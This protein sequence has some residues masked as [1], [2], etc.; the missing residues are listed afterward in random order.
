MLGLS[1]T[2]LSVLI[3]IAALATAL[4]LAVIS[5]YFAWRDRRQSRH[6]DDSHAAFLFRGTVLVDSTPAAQHLL[7]RRATC[8][9][10]S[11]EWEQLLDQLGHTFPG[12]RK[13]ARDGIASGQFLSNRTGD[14][15]VLVVDTWGEMVRITLHEATQRAA[16]VHP[17]AV[18]AMEEELE[19]LRTLSQ[20]APQLM[21]KEDRSGVVTWANRAYLE[22][23]DRAAPPG[24]D[25]GP[26]WP[27]HR[28]FDRLDAATADKPLTRRV[29]VT[30][31]DAPDPLWF[32]VTSQAQGAETAHF[33]TDAGAAVLAE[34][35]GR[36]FVQTLTKTFAQLSIGLAIFDRQRRLVMFNP[37]LLD[38]TRLPVEFLSSRPQIHGFLDRLR[39]RYMLPEPKNYSSWR[40]QVAALEIAAQEGT[41]CESWALPGGQTYKVTGRPHP[42]GAIA[43]T[44]ED[45]TAEI[46]LTRTFRTELETAQNVLEAMEE[47][48]A[49]FSGAG[50]LTMSNAAYS[51]VWGH[52]AESLGEISLKGEIKLWQERTAPTPL[53]ASLSQ[54]AR[55][56]GKPP[57]SRTAIRM[58]DGRA[59]VCRCV[60]IGGGSTLMAFQ[61]L[62]TGSAALPEPDSNEEP[63][64]E[65][66]FRRA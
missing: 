43:F 54:S 3:V 29:S 63:L 53:W 49:V 56:T 7:R 27:P 2:N 10:R 17:L 55:T 24:R 58:S 33:A 38:L 51:R 9:T 61:I 6:L 59:A 34:T 60:P 66:A 62:G 21:W 31:P 57:A 44:F 15:S 42:D 11:T 14:D 37:A 65:L 23:A 26:V 16:S 28:V 39:D 64:P 46:A 30:M 32:D 45:I 25:T 47:A 48:I 19:V 18:G 8:S 35:Q 50:T 12:L 52:S 41:Y 4:I 1:L 40:E 13:A 22:L 36:K 20:D 5:R